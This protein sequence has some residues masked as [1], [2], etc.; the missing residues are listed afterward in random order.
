MASIFIFYFKT[1]IFVFTNEPLLN[2][3]NYFYF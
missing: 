3:E 2:Y 1:K